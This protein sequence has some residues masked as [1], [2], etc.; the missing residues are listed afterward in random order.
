MSSE[1]CR[2]C[3]NIY[4]DRNPDGSAKGLN[5][6]L[7]CHWCASDTRPPGADEEPPQ[8]KEPYASYV[9]QRLDEAADQHVS[10]KALR[11]LAVKWNKIAWDH[12]S[13][14]DGN[15]Q[16]MPVG[17]AFF[18]CVDDLVELLNSSEYQ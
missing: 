3:G 9:Q 1:H 8:V 13:G 10:E 18:H 2:G 7:K 14:R 4:P 17:A 12:Y 15:V 11:A 6:D 5:T 16:N